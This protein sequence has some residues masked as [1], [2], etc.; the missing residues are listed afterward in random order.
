MVPL[1]APHPHKAMCGVEWG[2]VGWCNAPRWVPRGDLGTLYPPTLIR[3]Y[4]RGLVCTCWVS[5]FYGSCIWVHICTL[6][7]MHVLVDS[8][9]K[10]HT[11][12]KSQRQV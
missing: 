7:E 4:L 9:T 2:G 1:V 8:G 5:A 12:R 3:L 10:P 11:D 6:H